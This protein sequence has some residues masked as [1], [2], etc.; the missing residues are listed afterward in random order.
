MPLGGRQSRGRANGV[1]SGGK[2]C[3]R[4]QLVSTALLDL[5]LQSWA[6]HGDKPRK[7]PVPH[8]QHRSAGS[9][10]WSVRARELPAAARVASGVGG[11]VADDG[12]LTT[13]LGLSTESLGWES[14]DGRAHPPTTRLCRQ[15]DN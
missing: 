12:T 14:R 9:G 11:F 7:V 4:L 15:D 1:G 2:R 3:S 5:V 6:G 13:G 10:H 8:K